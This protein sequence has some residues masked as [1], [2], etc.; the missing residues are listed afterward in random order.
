ME[1]IGCTTPFGKDHEHI[2]TKATLSKKAKQIYW[3]EITNST[4]PYPCSFLAEFN[5]VFDDFEIDES[6]QIYLFF[7]EFIEI[8]ASKRIY[9]LED[10]YAAVGGY[11]G[12]FLGV[13]IF[14]I[15][16]VISFFLR[17]MF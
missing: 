7:K 17:K 9:G 13:S 2:C 1:D 6:R 10:L 4:C 5:V 14:S 16:D 8:R 3:N 11:T 15:H 12:L